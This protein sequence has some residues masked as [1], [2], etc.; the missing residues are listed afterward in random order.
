MPDEVVQDQMFWLLQVFWNLGDPDEPV[1]NRVFQVNG[2]KPGPPCPRET[3]VQPVLQHSWP[4]GLGSPGLGHSL[5]RPDHRAL[6]TTVDSVLQCTLYY[7][8]FTNLYYPTS[9]EA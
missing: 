9:S 6:C 3:C 8:A 5:D 4:G 1:P 7:R 2:T